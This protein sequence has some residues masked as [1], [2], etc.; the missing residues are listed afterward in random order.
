M[1]F[2]RC[3][4]SMLCHG[5]QVKI[6][7]LLRVRRQT[8]PGITPSGHV[9]RVAACAAVVPACRRR[10]AML[11]WVFAPREPI[12]MPLRSVAVRASRASLPSSGHRCRSDHHA[13]TLYHMPR[14][15]T[16]GQKNTSSHT[17][18]PGRQKWCRVLWREMR[19]CGARQVYYTCPT[20]PAQTARYTEY[21]T[22]SNGIP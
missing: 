3:H 14:S 13:N 21:T 2:R 6:D 5:R 22:A 10:L 18:T 19:A 17:I 8:A 9:S 1:I 15:D 7:A 4:V 20:R 11:A 12:T 16:L